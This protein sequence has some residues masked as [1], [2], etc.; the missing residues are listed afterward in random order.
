MADEQT[1]PRI[2]TYYRGGPLDGTHTTHVGGPVPQHAPGGDGGCYVLSAA[3]GYIWHTADDVERQR[4]A[5]AETTPA[6]QHCGPF[7]LGA[8][9]LGPALPE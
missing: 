5:C 8:A 4:K 6:G 3:E 7:C 2:R 9:G 1:P